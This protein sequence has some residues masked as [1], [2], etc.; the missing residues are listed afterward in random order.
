VTPNGA[1]ATSTLTITTNVQTAISQYRRYMGP[2]IGAE[3]SLALLLLPLI[4]MNRKRETSLTRF[5]GSL[6]VGIWLLQGLL[7]CSG[8]SQGSVTPPGQYSIT[9]TGASGT[10]S[11][12][13]TLQLVVQ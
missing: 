11:H 3:P 9:V 12:S 5:C 10:I 4:F 13:A 7:G 8:T 2:G 1:V 6:F